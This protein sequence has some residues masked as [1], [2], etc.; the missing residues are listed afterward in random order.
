MQEPFRSPV[1]R[2][3]NRVT[4]RSA[5]SRRRRRQLRRP[6][7][8]GELEAGV[9]DPDPQA[10]TVVGDVAVLVGTRLDTCGRDAGLSDLLAVPDR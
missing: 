8:L 9:A 7:G 1:V 5:T 2:V 6:R 4:R 10:A 3:T